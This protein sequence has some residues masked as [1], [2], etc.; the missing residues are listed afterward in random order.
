MIAIACGR[1]LNAQLQQKVREF[2]ALYNEELQS[3]EHDQQELEK[4]V[5]KGEIETLQ[6]HLEAEAKAQQEVCLTMARHF[7]CRVPGFHPL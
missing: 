7:A 6:G 3:Y 4:E 1:A 2:E 5:E